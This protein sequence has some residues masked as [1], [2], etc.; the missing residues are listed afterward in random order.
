MRT[1]KED[2]ILAALNGV[3]AHGATGHGE[4]AKKVLTVA[5]MV[6]AEMK[7]RDEADA[8]LAEIAAITAAVKAKKG[9]K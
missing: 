5:E 8:E 2:L 6:I 7:A 3:L 4:V 9:A 1:F